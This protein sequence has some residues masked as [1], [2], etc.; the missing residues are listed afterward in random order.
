MGYTDLGD[1]FAECKI[2]A[3][4][5]LFNFPYLYDGDKQEVARLYGPRATPHFF[6][7][8]QTRK[9]RYEG[10]LDDSERA[11]EARESFVR[12]TIESLLAGQPVPRETTPTPGCSIKWSSKRPEVEAYRKALAQEP[13][14][15]ED[16]GADVIRDLLKNDS[17]HL[18]LVTI[19]TCWTTPSPQE[20]EELV[21]TSRMYRERGV[22]FVT[23]NADTPANRETALKV[24]KE[25]Q[26]SNRNLYFRG[27]RPDLIAAVGRKWS[28]SF[29]CTLLLQAGGKVVYEQ[30]GPHE[31]LVLRRA[32]VDLLGRTY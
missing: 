11:L 24:L 15:L 8:D 30:Q 27:E 18:R 16:V 4:E 1:S 3:K 26:A 20:L 5:K 22:E 12:N 6:V 23:I 13:V 17:P 2:R 10:A 21:R 28:G 32:I 7:F 19:W 25:Q 31:P 14:T 29:P 9:L